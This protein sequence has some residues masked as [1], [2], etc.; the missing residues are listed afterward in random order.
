MT[1][2]SD[3]ETVAKNGA[4]GESPCVIGTQLDDS[5]LAKSAKDESFGGRC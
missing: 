1:H 3:D 2:L 4:P 5:S